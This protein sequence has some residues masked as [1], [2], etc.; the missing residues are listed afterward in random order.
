M[1]ITQLPDQADTGLPK[2]P[3]VVD[4]HTLQKR[5]WRKTASDG[6]EIAVD[7][8]QPAEHGDQLAQSNSSCYVVEQKPEPVIILTLPEGPQ[9]AAR[10]GWFLGNQ[11]L[12]VEVRSDC[13][14]V[15]D[16]PTLIDAIR[17]NHL[18]FR[19]G[20]EVFLADPHSR[21]VGHHHH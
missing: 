19:K 11:H 16:V 3:V 1:L 14:L 4:R 20:N 18:E 7:L 9:Q 21:G 10:L 12:P 15:E 8:E 6:E 17:R 13:V 2:I 5:R